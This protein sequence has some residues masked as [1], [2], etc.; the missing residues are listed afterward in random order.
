[1]QRLTPSQKI[2]DYYS[3]E[4]EI[5]EIIR[6]AHD[7]IALLVLR[8]KRD[9]SELLVLRCNVAIDGLKDIPELLR[10][11]KGVQEKRGKK[12]RTYEPL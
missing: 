6:H 8:H 3:R 1:M 5:C 9:L 2:L 7:T 4:N 11:R 10:K 12:R